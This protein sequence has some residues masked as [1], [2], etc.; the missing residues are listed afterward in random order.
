MNNCWICFLFTHILTK[1]TVQEAKSPVNN[2]VRQRCAR[3]L[4]PMLKGYVGGL[5]EK[6]TVATWSLGNHLS[7]CFQAQGNKEKPVPRQ[8]VA[9]PSGHWLPASNPATSNKDDTIRVFLTCDIK[10]HYPEDL[11]TRF[12]NS[13]TIPSVNNRCLV[14][15]S[16]KEMLHRKYL[17]HAPILTDTQ[18]CWMSSD[19]LH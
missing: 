10:R 19:S 7:I 9:A 5:H 11:T 13:I 1:L 6:H 2:L 12:I 3:D 8:P 16:K 15:E 4:I 14:I 18:G 17:L